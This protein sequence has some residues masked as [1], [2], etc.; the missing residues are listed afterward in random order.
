MRTL[1]RPSRYSF[2]IRSTSTQLP[3]ASCTWVQPS[4]TSRSDA[5]SSARSRSAAVV[6]GTKRRTSSC[7]AS[8]SIP[9][10]WLSP[11]RLIAPPA[12]AALLPPTPASFSAALLAMEACPSA[13]VSTTGLFGAIWSRS[14]R[15]G[16]TGGDQN[17]SIH[18]RPVT[19]SPGFARL[20]AA[21]TFARNA[22]LVRVP[23]RLRVISRRP[24]P[25]KC[26]WASTNP[27]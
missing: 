26:A 10:G 3:W 21:S 2:R 5:S 15:V 9:V 1:I 4:A 23:S 7:A 19:H 25:V 8:I 11:S 22:A 13:R 17:V 12:G 24:I 27:G 6:R 14:W 20:T 18:P 16:K